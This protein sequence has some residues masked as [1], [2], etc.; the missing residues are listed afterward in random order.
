MAT[1]ASNSI[2]QWDE[3]EEAQS[4][5]KELPE[6]DYEF[7]ELEPHILNDYK[8]SDWFKFTIYSNH[9]PC[10]G[11]LLLLNGSVY[12]VESILD[13]TDDDEVEQGLS[14]SEVRMCIV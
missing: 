5:E 8:V 7:S 3:L 2:L 13:V 14:Y 1:V 9:T 11:E 4:R 12:R 6:Y 10:E